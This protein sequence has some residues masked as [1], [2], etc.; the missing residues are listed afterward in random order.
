MRIDADAL[1]PFRSGISHDHVEQREDHP[2]IE[3]AGKI[4]GKHKPA[5]VEQSGDP[6]SPSGDACLKI[7]VIGCLQATRQPLHNAM[8]CLDPQRAARRQ[9]RHPGVIEARKPGQAAG[10]TPENVALME[11]LTDQLGVALDS[12]R[13]YQDTQRRAAEEQLIGQV[14]GRIRQSLDINTVLQTAARE[15]RQALNLDQVQVRMGHATHS[16]NKTQ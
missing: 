15:M 5:T 13:L 14:A 16:E 10:W 11:T 6:I 4:D 8:P 1:H 7:V 9:H 12:A 3:P 2:R